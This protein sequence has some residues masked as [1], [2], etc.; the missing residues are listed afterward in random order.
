MSASMM[1]TAFIFG[2]Y[3]SHHI[4]S[5]SWVGT[6]H[7][8][9]DG[10]GA[11]LFESK[12]IWNVLVQIKSFAITT[13]WGHTA[14]V[15]F[16][17][18]VSNWSATMGTGSHI[19]ANTRKGWQGICNFARWLS[20]E[21]CMPEVQSH[22]L[23]H[24]LAA[25]ACL[26]RGCSGSGRDIL[27]PANGTTECSKQRVCQAGRRFTHSLLLVGPG[28]RQNNPRPSRYHDVLA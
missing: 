6:L 23:E 27:T 8:L 24:V 14:A 5:T 25:H 15:K 19:T 9:R 17:S 22:S 16:T 13:I 1:V 11:C 12:R 3:S 7:V 4:W 10:T 21:E 26:G 18:A 28:A 20:L 2:R